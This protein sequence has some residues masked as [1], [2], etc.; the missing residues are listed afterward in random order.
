MLRRLRALI[1]LR[2][3]LFLR[4]GLIISLPFSKQ[5]V[6]CVRRHIHFFLESEMKRLQIAM[7]IGL[8]LGS[9]AP[10]ESVASNVPIATGNIDNP[11]LPGN[12]PWADVLG[13]T[14][15]S[16]GTSFVPVQSG[17]FDD[18]SLPGYTTYAYRVDAPTDWTN[19]DLKITLSSGRL[20]HLSPTMY[21]S[22]N[23]PNGLGDSAAMAPLNELGDL[24]S[25][26]HG[27]VGFV[28]EH[29]ETPTQLWTSWFTT[30]TDDLGTFDIAM[31]SLSDDANGTL[32]FRTIFGSEVLEGGFTT[33]ELPTHEIR[34]GQIVSLREQEPL[35]APWLRPEPLTPAE[36]QPIVIDPTL[37]T[38]PTVPKVV[39]PIELPEQPAPEILLVEPTLAEVPELET[40]STETPKT[41]TPKTE[42]IDV[43][44]FPVPGAEVIDV[45]HL[46]PHTPDEVVLVGWDPTRFT[47]I[48]ID[49][50]DC[51]IIDRIPTYFD[52]DLAFDGALRLFDSRT[53]N[54]TSE[55]T[56]VPEPTAAFLF[57]LGVASVL[58]QRRRSEIVGGLRSPSRFDLSARVSIHTGER[59]R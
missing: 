22:T 25:G 28:G 57:A 48:D 20:N 5:A 32:D 31:I 12:S 58:S 44:E 51:V 46:D 50:S 42:V 21:G 8:A 1:H 35:L 6:L 43:V 39:T 37:P 56:Q 53:V 36:Q 9:A 18:P 4:D 30:N 40:P 3:F 13:T 38:E 29:V 41:G 23:G 34:D 47:N 2:N 15:T 52:T 54:D 24:T 45:V 11:S 10:A 27:T 55:A 59:S 14:L 26:F 16:Y 7:C 49:C 33:G 19:T 17:N